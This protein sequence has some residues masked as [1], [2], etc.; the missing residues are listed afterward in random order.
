[1]ILVTGAT[2]TV[3]RLVLRQLS[4][5]GETVRAFVRNPEHKISFSESHYWPGTS[6]FCGICA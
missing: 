1:M 2:G 4:A 5:R 6:Q 3:G